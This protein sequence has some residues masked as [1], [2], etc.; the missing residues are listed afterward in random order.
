MVSMK[1]HGN[2]GGTLGSYKPRVCV[3]KNLD[4]VEC[5]ECGHIGLTSHAHCRKCYRGH[6][7][8]ID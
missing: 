2:K 8:S 5:L 1:Q 3:I 7:V 6:F 4:E